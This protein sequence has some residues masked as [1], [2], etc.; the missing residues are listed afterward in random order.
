MNCLIIAIGHKHNPHLKPLIA[1]YEKR[2]HG[3]L[4]VNWL[5]LAPSTLAN[6]AARRVESR[7]IAS[8]LTKRDFIIL[9]DERGTEWTSE[10]FSKNLVTWRESGRRLVFVIG[11]SY[12]IDEPLLSMAS[13]QWSL[14]KLVFPHQIV[15]LLLVEQLYRAVKISENHPYHH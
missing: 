2:L 6:M 3:T 11:G 5:L 9:L 4:S 1:D 7:L 13:A 14:S 12:G 15:R 10:A 8:K